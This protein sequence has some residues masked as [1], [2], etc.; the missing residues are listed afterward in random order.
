MKIENYEKA[1][2]IIRDLDNAKRRLINLTPIDVAADPRIDWVD[3]KNNGHV[4]Y[5]PRDLI[6]PIL[7]E[8]REQVEEQIAELEMQL[9]EL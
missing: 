8:Y 6:T 3:S 4:A 5:V 7:E 1:K 9:E 2:V